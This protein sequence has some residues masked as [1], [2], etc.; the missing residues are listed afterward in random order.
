MEREAAWSG[1]KTAERLEL[2][3]APAHLEEVFSRLAAAGAPVCALFGG[4]A[5]DA[6]LGALW[7]EPR[8]I[9][10]YD[11]RCWL[12][13]ELL[14][15]PDWENR[16]GQALLSAF[17][18][19]RLEMEPSA[20][21]GRLRHVLRWEGLELDISARPA[22]S[23]HATPAQCA[24]DRALDSDASLSAVAI[25]S[26]MSAWCESRYLGDRQTRTLSFYPGVE[27]DR[28]AAYSQRMT[29]KFPNASV[30]FLRPADSPAQPFKARG[31]A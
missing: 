16:F 30:C 15:Q 8:A 18:G 7:G 5:R 21:T 25:A 11:L 3:A 14:S 17:P 28:L 12:A 9:K 20:G 13:P 26:D 4:A 29:A 19:S 27:P 22:P 23:A 1:V 2:A 24:I 10:D 31:P 6:D